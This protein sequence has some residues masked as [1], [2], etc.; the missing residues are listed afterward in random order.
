MGERTIIRAANLLGINAGVEKGAVAFSET[1]STIQ[2]SVSF[3]S[4]QNI[5]QDCAR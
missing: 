5:I 3:F 4:E 2:T 1:P